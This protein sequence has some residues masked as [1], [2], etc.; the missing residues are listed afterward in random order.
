MITR[1]DFLRSAGGV[2]LLALRPLGQGLFAAPANAGARLPLF[3]VLPYI[4]PGSGSVLIDNAESMVIAWQT[5]PAMADF[6]VEFGAS[7]RYGRVATASRVGRTAGRGGD[8]E[9]RLNWTAV[10]DGL[11]LGQKHFYRVRGNGTTLAEGYFTTRQPRG[12]KTRFVSFG[13]NS[14]GDISDRAIA[15]HTYRQNPDFVMNCG[16]NVYESG[17]DDEYQRY[18]FP[19]YNADLAGE[20]VG[21]PLLRSVPFYTVIGNHDVQGK[22]ARGHEVANFMVNADALAYYTAMH[23]PL[24]GPAA[25]TFPTPMMGPENRI[26]AFRA[27]AGDRFPRMANYSFDY[28]DVHFLCLDSNRYTDPNDAALQKWIAD[29]LSRTDAIWKFVVY[30]HP[31]YNVGLEHYTVQHMRVLSPLLETHGVDFVLS[32]HE[33]N[34]QRAR[35]LRFKPS[36]PG[37]S[38]ILG[39]ADRRVPGAFTIDRSFD[40]VAN[41]RP[42]G[43]LHIVTGAGGKPLYE[44]QFTDNPASWIHADDDNIDYVT[45]M[46][47]DRHSLSV[48]EVDGT[49]LTMTQIDEAGHEIDRFVVTK[50]RRTS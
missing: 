43:V 33:H 47:S 49:H 18:F 20:R 5:L 6:S 22:D 9:T 13:D 19:V 8:G 50:G 11:R 16:D 48:F 37:K 15:F 31:A 36:G 30:H 46:V 35:P 44:P 2:T 1:R 41:T 27:C 28:G 45:K 10:L 12:Q 38:A 42:D 21:A 29:D 32:G 3:T 39:E 34:Y 40:G 14:Y 24:N 4:Q 17:T 7:P 26:A 25:P 23:L